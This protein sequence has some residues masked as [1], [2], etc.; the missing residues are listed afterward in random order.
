[1]EVKVIFLSFEDILPLLEFQ[2]MNFL[3]SKK[4][5]NLNHRIMDTIVILKKY[6]SKMKDCKDLKI[7]QKFAVKLFGKLK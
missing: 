1:M 4:G 5:Q 3:K 6:K 7:S 2:L